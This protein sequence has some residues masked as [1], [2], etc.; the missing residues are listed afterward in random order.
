[1]PDGSFL[2]EGYAPI[3]KVSGGGSLE[4]LVRPDAAAA[5]AACVEKSR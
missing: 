4:L 5:F 1:M 3:F 2:A